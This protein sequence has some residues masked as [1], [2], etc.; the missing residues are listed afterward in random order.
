MKNRYMYTF[1]IP[2]YYIQI[3]YFKNRDIT[4]NV[5]DDHFS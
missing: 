1:K 5:L 4:P 3:P 2:V